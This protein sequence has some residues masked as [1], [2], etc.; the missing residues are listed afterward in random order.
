MKADNKAYKELVDGVVKDRDDSKTNKGAIF[1]AGMYNYA[2]YGPLSP[3]TDILSEKQMR[4]VLP[5][6]LVNKFNTLLNYKHEV[7]YYG[8][9]PMQDVVQILNA[10]HLTGSNLADYPPAKKYPELETK[11]TKVLFVDYPMKQTQI[12]FVSKDVPMSLS[13]MPQARIFN[14]YFGSG[15]SSIVFQEIRETKGLAYS[16]YALY[17]SP[18]KKE[19]A[20]YVRA[21]VGCQADKMPEAIDA[22]MAIMQDMPRADDQFN[23]AVSSVEKQIESERVKRA[24]IFW[25]Y[26]SAQ[27]MGINYDYRRDI[28]LQA[29]GITL[30]DLEDFYNT[31]ISGR[32]YTILVMGDKSQINMDYLKKLGPVKEL[33][34]EEIFGY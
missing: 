13:L 3:M 27:D 31:H 9:K 26:K 2:K 33:T 1:N 12:M 20:H 25:S 18:A 34:L 24:A 14:E 16:A 30:D 21:F 10:Q 11:E 28:Y 4:N 17:T 19:D 32:N 29:R 8:N 22:M 15:L 6:D 23:N 7:F 5:Q